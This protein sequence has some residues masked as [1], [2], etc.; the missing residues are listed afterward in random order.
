RHAGTVETVHTAQ[1]PVQVQHGKDLSRVATLIGTG[2]VIVH[3][4][5]PRHLLEAALADRGDPFSLGPRDPRLLID[6]DYALFASGLLARVDRRVAYQ[7]ACN[8]LR[9]TADTIESAGGAAASHEPPVPIG[10]TPSPAT[11]LSGAHHGHP[12]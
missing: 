10:A 4:P 8:A 6:S 9:D 5:D 3:A 7:L 1:G 12:T 2:G 11:P